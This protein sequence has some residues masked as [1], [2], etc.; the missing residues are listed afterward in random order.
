[1]PE[2]RRDPIVDR[3]VIIA[4]NRAHRP[5]ALLTDT[6]DHA[7]A[8]RSAEETYCP[9][10]PGNE[11]ET[12]A[13]V[14]AL[15]DVRSAANSPGWR[16]RVVPNKYPALLSEMASHG[17]RSTHAH[18]SPS[19]ESLFTR[20]P[21]FGAHEVII[22][23]PRHVTTVGD[24][25]DHELAD[26]LAAVRARLLA[27]RGQESFRHAL[28]F[29]NVGRA[30][31]ATREHLHSQLMAG[32]LV[33][34]LVAEELRGARRF[35]DEFGQC[36]FCRMIEDERNLAVRIV[37]ESAAFVALCP[38]ASRFAY[39]MWVLP[40]KHA[41][42]FDSIENDDLAD[43]AK[44]ARSAIA[45]IESLSRPPAYNLVIHTSPFDSSAM[46]HY[47]WHMEVFPRLT[48]AAG[49]EWGSGCA[50]N[51]VSPEAAAGAL[52]DFGKERNELP[53]KAAG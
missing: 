27:M 35:F 26:S 50:V 13:E 21:A 23:T 33:P 36:V 3:W 11:S 29:K 32:N 6:G 30:A 44:L 46:E 31:G 34:P 20:A 52:R 42:H 28:V 24:L 41:P 15:R 8:Q 40:K 37:C 10:C 43:L 7:N 19:A 16:V 9:F 14:F 48:I 22:D 53:R 1:M 18:L 4:E 25:T 38:F 49:Y 39:E 17:D 2:L 45:K 5:G 47:H 51:P 12:P